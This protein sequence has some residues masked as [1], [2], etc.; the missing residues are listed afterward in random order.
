M[1][2]IGITEV[3]IAMVMIMVAVSKISI[4]TLNTPKN[5]N[6]LSEAMLEALKL[7]LE[8]MLPPYSTSI[9]CPSI[10][11]TS[12]GMTGTWAYGV[13]WPYFF[14]PYTICILISI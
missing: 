7:N 5:L 3:C 12:F 8:D 13:R 6:A 10:W 11:R 2:N 1:R 4:L 9:P 14:D